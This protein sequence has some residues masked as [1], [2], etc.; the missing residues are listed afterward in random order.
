MR[1]PTARGEAALLT[2][3]PPFAQVKALH[4]KNAESARR[5]AE[6]GNDKAPVQAP[7]AARYGNTASPA[8]AV[9]KLS[10]S[11]TWCWM[12]DEGVGSLAHLACASAAPV[13]VIE[14]VSRRPAAAWGPDGVQARLARVCAWHAVTW[15]GVCSS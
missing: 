3:G 8:A 10:E 1:A 6:G 5:K 4:Q 15:H 11:A 2:V 12:Q 7:L 13:G 9:G 14:Y